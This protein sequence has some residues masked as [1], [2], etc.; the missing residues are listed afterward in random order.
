MP[1][2]HTWIPEVTEGNFDVPLDGCRVR[3]MQPHALAA[4]AWKTR[5]CFYFLGCVTIYLEL[6]VMVLVHRLIMV[7]LEL[8]RMVVQHHV[9]M[10]PEHHLTG[11]TVE[12]HHNM[13]AA[14][15]Q[16]KDITIY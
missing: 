6:Q 4:A 16:V 3:R 5:I 10:V 12:E 2:R 7:V 15:H 11:R 9:L 1:S 13:M 8:L 14:E